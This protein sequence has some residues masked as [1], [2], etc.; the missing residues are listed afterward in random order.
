MEDLCSLLGLLYSL[1]PSSTSVHGPFA[2]VFVC[3][4]IVYLF[5]VGLE[6]PQSEG[7]EPTAGLEASQGEGSEPTAGLES[8][9]CEGSEPTERLDS[10][11]C[12]RLSGEIQGMTFRLFLPYVFMNTGF[13]Q[14]ISSQ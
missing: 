9:Q 13:P 8:S 5:F 1:S 10:K 12:F 3:M 14:S 4:F 2:V 7:S 11:I 6:A